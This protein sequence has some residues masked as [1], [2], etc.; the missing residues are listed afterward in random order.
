[1][2]VFWLLSVENINKFQTSDISEP[3]LNTRYVFVQHSQGRASE[4]FIISLILPMINSCN[5]LEK[6]EVFC[7]EVQNEINEIQECLCIAY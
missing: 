4:G 7:S 1:M 5:H 6:K 3:E 2:S